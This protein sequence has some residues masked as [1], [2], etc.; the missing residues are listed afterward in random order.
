MMDEAMK[1]ALYLP[2][3]SKA[4]AESKYEWRVKSVNLNPVSL[5]SLVDN[6]SPVVST[7]RSSRVPSTPGSE[8]SCVPDST[9]VQVWRSIGVRLY[10]TS[11]V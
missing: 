4:I 6:P 3:P 2:F 8:D 5:G 7:N 11:Q 10:S 1:L 9:T